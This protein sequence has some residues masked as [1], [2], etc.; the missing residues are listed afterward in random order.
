MTQAPHKDPE[1]L[2]IWRLEAVTFLFDRLA[3][4]ESSLDDGMAQAVRDWHG[5]VVPAITLAKAAHQRSAA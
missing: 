2:E 5:H 4:F 3:E 1:Q